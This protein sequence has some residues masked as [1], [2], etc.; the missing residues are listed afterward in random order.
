MIKEGS[1]FMK[2]KILVFVLIL[3]SLCFVGCGEEEKI[4]VG[5]GGKVIESTEN[6]ELA[7]SYELVDWVNSGYEGTIRTLIKVYYPIYPDYD[8]CYVEIT[9]G[10]AFI[11]PRS[12][13]FII[14]RDGSTV[15]EWDWLMENADLSI[16]SGVEGFECDL[17]YAG[18]DVEVSGVNY[19]IFYV[20]NPEYLN[21]RKVDA[22]QKDDDDF[23]ENDGI[24]DPDFT[25]NVESGSTAEELLIDL[26]NQGYTDEDIAKM[27]DAGSDINGIQLT[28]VEMTSVN[29]TLFDDT[30]VIDYTLNFKNVSNYDIKDIVV[31]IVGWDADDFPLLAS[32]TYPYYL[33]ENGVNIKAD[34]AYSTQVKIGFSSNKPK[35]LKV[36]VLSVEGFANNEVYNNPTKDLFLELYSGKKFDESLAIEFLTVTYEGE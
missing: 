7:S 35:H 23:Y 33:I 18:Q 11:D 13:G 34:G 2:N 16:E 19:P 12:E 26:Y 25:W 30:V 32:A 5:I 20:D 3:C 28:G 17:T 21:Y 1:V 31:L 36:Y 4:D 24:I 29:D 22:S 9:D 15:N 10:L 14:Q 6:K 8:N 27:L